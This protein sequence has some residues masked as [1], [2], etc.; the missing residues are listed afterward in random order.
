[1]VWQ[2]QISPLER[3]WPAPHTKPKAPSP[4]PNAQTITNEREISTEV[5]LNLTQQ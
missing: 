5:S 1:V 3:S 4:K 2:T